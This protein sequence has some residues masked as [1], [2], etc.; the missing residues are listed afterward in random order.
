MRIFRWQA[1]RGL[2]TAGYDVASFAELARGAPDVDVLRIS[3][4]QN[5]VL[6]TFDRDFGELIYR[7]LAPLPPGV[8]YLRVAASSPEEPHR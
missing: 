4:E 6:I 5:R 1:S 8:I 7:D 2:R 3:C